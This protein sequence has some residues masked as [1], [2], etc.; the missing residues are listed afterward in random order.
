MNRDDIQETTRLTD[1]DAQGDPIFPMDF[2]VYYTWNS[3]G[4]ELPYGC[5]L[6]T[7]RT[8]NGG[9]QIARIGYFSYDLTRTTD[10][11]GNWGA[12]SVIDESYRTLDQIR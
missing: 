3:F 2:S 12:W 5:T 9:Y 11:S 4:E 7:F 6:I 8:E 1:L 10:S